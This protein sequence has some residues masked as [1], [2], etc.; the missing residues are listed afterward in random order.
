MIKNLGSFLE[1]FRNIKDPKEDRQR[2]AGILTRELGFQ[3]TEDE[4]SLKNNVL[5]MT[6]DNYIK[7]EIFMRKESLLE[8]LKKES[9]IV[10]EI[11]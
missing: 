11:R 10:I 4:V 2:I 5:T 9:F 3:V 8:A 1:R 7:A 6:V